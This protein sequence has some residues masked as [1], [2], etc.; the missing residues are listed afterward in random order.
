M[1]ERFITNVAIGIAGAVVVV[2]SQAF[3]VSRT[4]WLTFGVSLGALALLAIAQRDRSRGRI[5]GMLDVATGALAL[6]SAVASVVYSGTTLKWLS[7]SE[8]VALVGLAIVGLVAHE[9]M[10]ERIVHQFEAVPADV[11]DGRRSEEIQ[12]AA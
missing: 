8:G 9:L 7:F 10:T 2:A 1:S 11:R 12:A 6:W 5:Q 3:S 4:G